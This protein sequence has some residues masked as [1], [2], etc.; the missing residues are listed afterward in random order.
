MFSDKMIVL[1]FADADAQSKTIAYT[2]QLTYFASK[3]SAR[4]KAKS[5]IVMASWFPMK[6]VRTLTKLT[7]SDM[8][9]DYKQSFTGYNTNDWNEVPWS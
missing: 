8:G 7:Y 1:P 9:I 5:D 6:V 2:K 4:G 3:N